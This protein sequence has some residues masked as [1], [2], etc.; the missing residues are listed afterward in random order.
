MSSFTSSFRPW[1]LVAAAL[2]L[3]EAG[4]AVFWPSDPLDRTNL[5]ELSFAKSEAAQRVFVHHKLK[6][7]ADMDPTIVQAGDS[8]GFYGIDPRVVMSHLPKGVTY[9]NQSCC[10]NLGFNGYLNILKFMLQRNESIRYLVL[11][12]T[13]YTMPRAEMWD[14]DGAALWGHPDITVFGDTIKQEYLSPARWL[15]L[16]SMAHRHAVTDAIY[17][18]RWL[19]GEPSRPLMDSVHYDDFLAIYEDSLGWMPEYDERVVVPPVECEMPLP[20]F[21]DL[22][23]FEHKT[24]LTEVLESFA[25]L[26]DEHDTI[27]VVVFQPVACTAGD[28][29]QAARDELERFQAGHPDVEIPFPLIE[30]WPSDLFSVPAHIK[31]E[32]TD[33]VGHRLGKA[34]AEII[35]RRGL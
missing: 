33:V 16:P 12:F 34:M 20:T 8:S 22:E 28:S 14:G 25:A 32:H 26:A 31:K 29:N 2:L 21:F 11:H 27:L 5:L 6:S 3:T 19:R 17:H 15:H 23:S 9:A 30:T 13:P 24:Y 10:A 18:L 1:L 4:V 7:F 35:E